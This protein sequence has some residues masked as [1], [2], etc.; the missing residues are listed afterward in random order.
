MVLEPD[1]THADSSQR[2]HETERVEPDY[3]IEKKKP[4]KPRE[5][6]ETKADEAPEVIGK[7]ELRGE[8]GRGAMGIVYRAYDRVLKRTVALK[9]I[10]DPRRASGVLLRR[11]KTE[12]SGL[13]RLHDPR[14]ITVYE[15]GEHQGKPYIV[16]E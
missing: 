9:M 6:Q 5:A 1:P 3:V 8:L 11:F 10:I 15:V 7:Y 13:A 4:R 12:A 14:I 16:M 2:R